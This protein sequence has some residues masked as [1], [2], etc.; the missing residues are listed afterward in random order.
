MAEELLNNGVCTLGK[1]LNLAFGVADDD[2]HPLAR[3]AE[4]NNVQDVEY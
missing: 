4:L 2:R 3:R 1:D